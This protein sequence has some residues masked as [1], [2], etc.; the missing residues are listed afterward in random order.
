MVFKRK[1][2]EPVASMPAPQ[3]RDETKITLPSSDIIKRNL[4]EKT[5]LL[6]N[7]NPVA[8]GFFEHFAD[9]QQ[10]STIHNELLHATW[11]SSLIDYLQY[12]GEM[13]HYILIN[14]SFEAYMS[15]VGVPEKVC[16]EETKKCRAAIL[17]QEY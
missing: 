2:S 14:T 10:H 16:L 5:D 12:Q 7:E 4:A 6:R 1:P 3:L 17:A 8:V 13:T 11:D 15:A 9:T